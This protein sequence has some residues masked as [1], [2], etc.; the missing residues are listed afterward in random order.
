MKVT[1]WI[2]KIGTNQSFI[3]FNAHWGVCYCAATQLHRWFSYWPIVG[4]IL[5]LAAIKEYVFD[6]LYETPH[7]TPLDNTEDWLG[8]AFGCL[9]AMVLT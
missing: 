1:A 4:T 8:Y 3:A 6:R 2:A 7:Q 9:L 5:V